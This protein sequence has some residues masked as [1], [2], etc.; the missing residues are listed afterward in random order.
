M[1]IH[2]LWDLL[3]STGP[4]CLTWI[5]EMKTRVTFRSSRINMF[6]GASMTRHCYLFN[7][8]TIYLKFKTISVWV[9][10]TILL[11]AG[12][13]T[14]KL[15]INP[16]YKYGHMNL[17]VSKLKKELCNIIHNTLQIITLAHRSSH[18]LT[19]NHIGSQ[20]ITLAKRSSY[21]QQIITLAHTSSHW[22]TLPQ[23]HKHS[24][25]IYT[26][27]TY[28]TYNCHETINLGLNTLA[29]TSSELF[30]N[31]DV[32]FV[33]SVC[34]CSLKWLVT[35]VFSDSWY[36]QSMSNWK[37]SNLHICIL[38]ILPL[39]HNRFWLRPSWSK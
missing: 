11:L 5:L 14:N 6:L 23:F 36:E 19:D 33:L 10:L 39:S 21:C 34:P 15:S 4:A 8:F 18:W 26:L 2:G 27:Q 38:D 24:P 13:L 32:V 30:V 31:S 35:W 9:H 12:G 28:F 16:K 17:T 22:G 25:I 7:W 37:K 3:G 1:Y 29:Q 20:I